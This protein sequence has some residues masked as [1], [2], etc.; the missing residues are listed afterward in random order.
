MP[1][2][3]EQEITS[4]ETVIGIDPEVSAVHPITSSDI[5]F[6]SHLSG[7]HEGDEINK[8]GLSSYIENNSSH[9]QEET[10]GDAYHEST[11]NLQDLR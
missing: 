5:H 4:H 3:I 7:I 8:S 11:I 9:E 10:N 2:T 6:R 1:H